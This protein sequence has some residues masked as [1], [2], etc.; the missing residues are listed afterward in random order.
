LASNFRL[1]AALANLA[2]AAERVALVSF[3]I[4]PLETFKLAHHPLAAGFIQHA[5]AGWKPLCHHSAA[6]FVR[7]VP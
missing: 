6:Q 1:I 2:M 5:T 3:W 4:G 7:P